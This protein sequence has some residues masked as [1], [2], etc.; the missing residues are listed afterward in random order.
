MASNSRSR[1]FVVLVTGCSQGGIG[2]E[3]CCEFA[4]LGHIVYATA[5]RLD[6]M[7]GLEGIHTLQLDVTDTATIKAAVEVV[8]AAEEHIDILVNNAGTFCVMPM[9]EQDLDAARREYDTNV[10][11]PLA[12]AQAVAPSMMKRR[13]GTIVNVGSVAGLNA[14]PW[15]G[16]Y[17]S[18]KA[19]LHTWTTSM[20][21]ELRPY[22]VNTVLVGVKSQI[23]PNSR[24]HFEWKE[25]S[26]FAPFKDVILRHF[27]V[28]PEATP[29]EEFCQYVVPRILQSPPPREIYYGH[30][31]TTAW[32]FSLL[33]AFIK[34]YVVGKIFVT[35][36][37][38]NGA[39]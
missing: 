11:G 18:S 39:Q 35:A 36:S 19:A 31:S 30:Q 4:K 33:P 25:N 20:R 38:T 24:A 27:D 5:R 6:A 34:D 15:A 14:F 26:M 22:N 1:P 8:L 10:W 29:T 17:A 2:Y 12:V 16:V 21:A 32:M 23:S 13:A 9:L 37:V 3:L 28:P 7:R